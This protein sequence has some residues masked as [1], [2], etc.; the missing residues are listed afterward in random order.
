ML[1]ISVKIVS[2]FSKTNALKYA[3]GIINQYFFQMQLK[4]LYSQANAKLCIGYTIQEL[5][6]LKI[7]GQKVTA[8]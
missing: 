3:E 1:N 5:D 4:P 2:W 7:T 6:A 8:Y